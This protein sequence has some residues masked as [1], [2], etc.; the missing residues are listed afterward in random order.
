MRKATT[1]LTR[2]AWQIARPGLTTLIASATST[3]QWAELAVAA[4]LAL[5]AEDIRTL[6][7][8]SYE[9][10]ATPSVV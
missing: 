6:D 7:V 2:A 3:A 8:A 1:P 5:L 4:R 10:G 9:P